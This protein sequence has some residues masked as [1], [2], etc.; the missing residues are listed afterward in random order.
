LQDKGY[1]IK[2]YQPNSNSNTYIVSINGQN[3]S[4]TEGSGYVQITGDIDKMTDIIE[5]I[6][7]LFIS[8]DTERIGQQLYKETSLT[9][10]Y[11][12]VIASIIIKS[13]VNQ[14]FKVP[15]GPIQDLA[16]VLSILHGSDVINVVKNGEGNNLPLYQMLC[17]SYRHRDIHKRLLEDQNKHNIQTPY[18]Y[19][20]AYNNIDHIHAPQIRAGVLAKDGTYKTAASLSA[21]EVMH[22]AILHDFYDN[23]TNAYTLDEN[24]GQRSGIVGFQ[25]HVY[26]DKNKHFIQMFDLSA[27]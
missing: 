3:I 11:A 4:I 6:V 27:E 12:P 2:V 25:S 9:K 21:D 20:I 26:S 10:L 24:S 8:E 16:R 7:Q 1:S 22:L 15:F 5:D 23:L 14:D 18:F 13:Q 17:L 19:N